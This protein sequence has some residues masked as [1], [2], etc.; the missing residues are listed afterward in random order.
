MKI[1]KYLDSFSEYLFVQNY[2]SRTIESYTS[3]VKAFFRFIE[4]HYNRIKSIEMITVEI[5]SDYRSYLSNYHTPRGSI[6][7][8]ST[9][10]NIL[11]GLKCFFK[12]M[13]ENDYIPINPLKDIRLP[14]REDGIIRNILSEDEVKKVLDSLTTN[15][16]LQIRNRAIIELLYSCG[17]RTTE[18][19]NLKTSEIDLKEQTITIVKGKGKKT[20]MVP[21]GQYATEYLRLYLE[22]SRR[23]LLRGKKQDPGNVFLSNT[24]N[25]F[26]KC[27]LNSSVIA[28]I[29]KNA[30]IGK[31]ISAYSFRHSIATHLLENKVDIMYIARLLGHKSLNTTQRYTR[32]EISDLKRVHSLTH[33]RERFDDKI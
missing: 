29:M 20:R 3:S 18:L 26:E 33:P 21:I 13:N 28:P 9:Q 15:T 1:D 27:S 19:C 17:I 23:F 30:K 7:T 11:L 16:P 8:S 2:S 24:G 10:L 12:Y 14:R 5:L 22:K 31:H 25:P 32:V 6:L 4:K